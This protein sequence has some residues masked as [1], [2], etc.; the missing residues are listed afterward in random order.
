MKVGSL[1]LAVFSRLQEVSSARG[2]L[3][4]GCYMFDTTFSLSHILTFS[5]SHILTLSR[6]HILTLSLSYT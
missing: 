2:L 1:Q 3:R 5:L 4:D 6:S